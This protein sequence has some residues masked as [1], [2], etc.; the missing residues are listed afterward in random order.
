MEPHKTYHYWVENTLNK[1]TQ[2][3][4]NGKFWMVTGDGNSPKVR[5][6]SKES[7]SQE[8]ARLAA[9]NPGMYYYVL[10]A[11]ESVT[12]PVSVIHKSL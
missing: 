11:T 10:E 3:T 2:P 5:H 9:A 4:H 6:S 1:K 7:A 12:Q 8:A